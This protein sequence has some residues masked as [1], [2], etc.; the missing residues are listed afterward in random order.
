LWYGVRGI[1]DSEAVVYRG[2]KTSFTAFDDSLKTTVSIKYRIGNVYE[3]RDYI[4]NIYT[5]SIG[6]TYDLTEKEKSR[7]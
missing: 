3:K 7:K 4:A 6:N 2:R 5:D 1:V